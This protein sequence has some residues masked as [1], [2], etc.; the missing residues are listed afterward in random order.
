MKRKSNVQKIDLVAEYLAATVV[1]SSW[2]DEPLKQD[3]L[4]PFAAYL[5]TRPEGISACSRLKQCGNL[6]ETVDRIYSLTKLDADGEDQFID[7]KAAK[8]EEEEQ[9]REAA[10]AKVAEGKEEQEEEQP[11][12]K[13]LSYEDRRTTWADFKDRFKRAEKLIQEIEKLTAHHE[14]DAVDVRFN[15]ITW[16]PEREKFVQWIETGKELAVRLHQHFKTVSH[17]RHEE[18]DDYGFLVTVFTLHHRYGCTYP[19][20]AALIASGHAAWGRIQAANRFDREKLRD[21]LKRLSQSLPELHDSVES[22]IKS[23][24]DREKGKQ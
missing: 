20:V 15:L 18:K 21:D 8:M 7:L 11:E 10:K 2:D 12:S 23:L 24:A 17:A 1:D 9:E 3:W 5:E 22:D 16:P 13:G 14:G 19:Q 4:K 6:R